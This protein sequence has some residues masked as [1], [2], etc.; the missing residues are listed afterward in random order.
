MQQKEIAADKN[1]IACCG[2]YCGACR[3][4]LYGKCLGCS[5]DKKTL[6]CKIMVC[7]QTK[8]YSSCAQCNE[9]SDLSD[10]G[11]FN[12]IFNRIFG[13]IFNLDRKACISR[14]REIGSETYAGEM[15]GKKL[16][17]MKR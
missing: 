10:C 12:S 3:S 6:R 8:G 7:N 11:K 14:I 13:L 16:R 17:G 2:C 1:L 4:Y 5:K 9:F 15:A